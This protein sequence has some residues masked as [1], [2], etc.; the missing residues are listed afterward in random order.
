MPIS[1]PKL[2]YAVDALAPAISAE[3]L[4]YHY[5]FH[6]A[7]YVKAVNRL[8]PAH[9][10]AGASLEAV[11]A[12]ASGP[13]VNAAAQVFNHTLYW[14]SMAP[15]SGRP[16]AALLRAIERSF[17]SRTA[18]ARRFRAEA[19]QLFGSGWVWLVAAPSGALDVVATPN[20]G[21][22]VHEEDLCPLLICDVWE[23]AYYSDYRGERGAYLDVFWRLANWL[24]ASRR[25]AAFRA[26]RDRRVPRA[27][28]LRVRRRATERVRSWHPALAGRDL[29]E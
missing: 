23:H 17:G 20:A 27:R 5:A 16:D 28:Q 11:I 4:R 25:F 12:R 7:G 9:G 8:A 26:S 19:L 6:H 15:V 14:Q 13:L 18:L 10:L 2:P 3:A 29:Q 22:R 1:L 21:L 24:G